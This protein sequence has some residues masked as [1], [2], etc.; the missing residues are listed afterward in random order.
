[1]LVIGD[2]QAAKDAPFF[3]HNHPACWG[4]GG[5]AHGAFH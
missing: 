1:V 2:A 4:F 3:K 5:G